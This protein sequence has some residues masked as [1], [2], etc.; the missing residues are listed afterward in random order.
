MGPYLLLG[1]AI[2]ALIHGFVPRHVLHMVFGGQNPL[3]IPIAAVV[4][5]PLYVSLSGMLPIAESLSSQGIAI[6]T[7]LAFVIGGAGVSLPNLVLLHKLFDRR[8]LM[9]Y[10]STV[11]GIAISVGG[12]FNAILL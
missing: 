2:G 3:A 4:G 12:V 1:M 8:L 6:G 11:V 9:L 5:A 7:V 10:A